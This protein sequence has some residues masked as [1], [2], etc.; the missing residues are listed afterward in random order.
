M[1]LNVLKKL[2]LLGFFFYIPFQSIAWGLL[3]H[4][5]IG[6]IAE[7]HLSAKTRTIIQ[8]ILG[9]ESIA[10]AT[11]WADFI[12]SDSTFNYLGPWHYINLK[13]GMSNNEVQDYL[14][15]DTSINAYTR[16]NFLVKELKKKILHRI[17]SCFT[18]GY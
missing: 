16:I 6:E 8:H 15:K 1:I 18:C 5:I 3:G 2:L 17:T 13:D 4:R 14:K 9:T 11:N 7:H 12:K 10:M